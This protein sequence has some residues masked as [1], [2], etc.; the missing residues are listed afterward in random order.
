MAQNVQHLGEHRTIEAGSY[1]HTNAG[2][3]NLECPVTLRDR[4][5]R[6]RDDANE[7]RASPPE[8]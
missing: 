5:L 8:A 3:L 1:E 4:R 2:D 6:R 7:P